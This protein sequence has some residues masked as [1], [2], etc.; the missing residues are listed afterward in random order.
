MKGWPFQIVK[1]NKYHL[2]WFDITET[3]EQILRGN[4]VEEIYDALTKAK[5]TGWLMRR[6]HDD[7]F[8]NTK[9]SYCLL[10]GALPSD[11]L[12][13]DPLVSDP[14]VSDPLVSD[15]LVSDPLQLDP[16]PSSNEDIS[17]MVESLAS[18]DYISDW[19]FLDEIINDESVRSQLETIAQE[20]VENYWDG[21]F[22]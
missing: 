2:T 4:P 16:L 7:S 5:S 9:E 22:D 6:I 11:P 1:K 18:S 3:R 12:A 17:N 10:S 21:L 15:P 19:S 13:S 8:T 20:P 14:L